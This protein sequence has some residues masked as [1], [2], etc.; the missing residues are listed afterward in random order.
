MWSVDRYDLQRVVGE[1]RDLR[2]GICPATI[3]TATRVINRGKRWYSAALTEFVPQFLNRLQR[4]VN[5]KV[6]G[7]NPCPG[8]NL[9]SNSQALRRSTS[10]NRT[11]RH[12]QAG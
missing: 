6:Q 8:A 9:N 3:R 11:L 5:R 12:P 4:S 10:D 2:A 1:R 7:S